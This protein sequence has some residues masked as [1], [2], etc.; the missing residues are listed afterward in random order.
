MEVRDADGERARVG[1]GPLDPRILAEPRRVVGLGELAAARAVHGEHRVGGGP[2]ASGEDLEAEAVAFRRIESIGVDIIQRPERAGDRGG[3]RH[4]LGLLRG[5]GRVALLDDQRQGG[6]HNRGGRRQPF[7]SRQGD[8]LRAGREV[9][10]K[11]ERDRLGGVDVRSVGVQ[12]G[13]LAGVRGERE[14]RGRH[15]A[16]GRLKDVGPVRIAAVGRVADLNQIRAVGRELVGK[17]RVGEVVIV[18]GGQFAAGGVEELQDRVEMS[19]KVV[20]LVLQ[21]VRPDAER[22]SLPG[23]GGHGEPIH[24]FDFADR[25]GDDA[26]KLQQLSAFGIIIALVVGLGDDGIV[27][28]DDEADRGD[29][30][31]RGDAD[32]PRA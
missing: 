1:G 28:H 13:R 21:A 15:R 20:N 25:A 14:D 23:L 10:G 4:G 6:G 16:G 3:Q 19:L 7:R 30:L 27:D 17:E 2:G 22:Q 5:V 26:R 24:V 9:A 12:D 18:V 29:A 8:Q 32:F 11:I 31:R